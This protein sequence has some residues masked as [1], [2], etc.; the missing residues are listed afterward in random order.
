MPPPV[1]VWNDVL[2]SWTAVFGPVDLLQHPQAATIEFPSYRFSESGR[3]F[4][5]YSE[6]SLS[7]ADQNAVRLKAARSLAAEKHRAIAMA[8]L[9]TKQHRHTSKGTR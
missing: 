5:V 4:V 9:R 3:E 8:W 7:E 6:K 1:A 2:P